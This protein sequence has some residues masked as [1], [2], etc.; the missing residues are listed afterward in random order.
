MTLGIPSRPKFFI[1][2]A[3]SHTVSEIHAFLHFTQTTPYT[4]W[5]KT[6]FK[7]LSLALFPRQMCFC[8]LR[9]I[10]RWLLKMAGKWFLMKSGGWLC[11]YPVRQ[12]FCQPGSIYDHFRDK[13]VFEFYAEMQEGCQKCGKTIWPKKARSLC[14]YPADKKFHWNSSNKYFKMAAKNSEKMI[15]GQKCQMILHIPS[16]PKISS[17]YRSISHCFSV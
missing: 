5:A 8:V 1:Q 2:I 15:F 17:N 12:T 3:L 10:S 9:R 13:C 11:I 14:I 6:F 7:S 16:S 4:L